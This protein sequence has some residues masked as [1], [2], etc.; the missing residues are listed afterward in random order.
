MIVHEDDLMSTG[1][2]VVRTP[3]RRYTVT[4]PD[5]V[6]VTRT[7]HRLYTHA[8]AV[9]RAVAT[10][11]WPQIWLVA[12]FCGSRDLAEKQVARE[13]RAR[14]WETKQLIYDEAQV[15]AVEVA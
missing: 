11:Y 10:P 7:S 14:L 15:L 9:H 4:L 5:G 13:M 12:G 8:V 6:R 3:R 2:V 1:G